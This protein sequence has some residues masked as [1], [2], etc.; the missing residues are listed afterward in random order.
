[1]EYIRDSFYESLFENAK[2]V[3]YSTLKNGS[4]AEDLL[5]EIGST[6]DSRTSSGLSPKETSILLNTLKLKNEY[7]LQATELIISAAQTLRWH[8]YQGRVATMVPIELTSFCTS[9]CKFCGWRADNKPMPR[10]QISEDGLLQQV[11]L[12]LTKGFSHFELSGADDLDLYKNKLYRYVKITKE[13][14]ARKDPKNRLSICLTPFTESIY[15]KLIESGVDA[16]LNWQE[17][18]DPVRFRQM[19]T[20][21]PKAFGVNDDFS[22]NANSVGYLQR[23]KAQEFAVRARLQVGVGVMIGLSLEVETDILAT[24]MHARELIDQYDK[25]I[26]PIII[27]M[28]IWNPLTTHRDLNQIDSINLFDPTT[29]FNLIAAIYLLSLPNYYAWVF[30][31]CRVPLDVQSETVRTAGVFTST[32]VRLNPGGYL[33]G[34]NIKAGDF[35]RLSTNTLATE[36]NLL[37][38]EQFHHSFH[39]HSTYLKAFK[40][41]NL[42]ICNDYDLMSSE[43]RSRC[44]SF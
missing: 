37:K 17:T 21:G 12:L 30:P 23:M 31:N 25:I 15:S 34:V 19:I 7:R 2:S 39:D 44:R 3:Y 8:C 32:M 16:V 33:D 13:Q 18:Y 27:G 14:I 1:M 4:M 26:L 41:L 5:E 20:K 36:Q 40:D 38:A 35:S 11:D 28:P 9:V 43:A 42:A 10:F 24:V 29:N 22:F 6:L